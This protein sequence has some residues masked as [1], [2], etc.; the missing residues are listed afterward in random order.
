MPPVRRSKRLRQSPIGVPSPGRRDHNPKQSGGSPN[1]PQTHSKS[2]KAADNPSYLHCTP[3]EITH[4]TNI[5]LRLFNLPR[6]LFDEIISHLTPISTAS[7]SL[8]CKTALGVLGTSSWAHTGPSTR[9]YYQR[10]GLSLQALIQKDNP[11]L[12]LC[13]ICNVLHPSMKPPAA[14]RMTK[15]TRRC[16]GSGAFM[17]YWPLCGEGGYHLAYEHIEEVFAKK[18]KGP[19]K[20]KKGNSS[21]LLAR[22]LPV[23]L[24]KGDFTTKLST[25]GVKGKGSGSKVTYRLASSAYW[26]NDNLVLKQEH[27]VSSA[28][29]KSPLQAGTITSLP[30]R[31]CAHL[32]T[33]TAP[34]PESQRT[35]H[36]EPNGS[37]L[38]RAIV[39]AFPV[40]RTGGLSPENP[41]TFR[42]PC[43]SEKRQID[44]GSGKKD[45]IW[46]CRACPTKFRVTHNP[47]IGELVVTAWHCFGKGPPQAKKYWKWF[48]RR[49]NAV[50]G[51]KNRNSEYYVFDKSVPNFLVELDERAGTFL[52]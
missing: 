28:T 14:H 15:W 16:L 24:L 20:R 9:P 23:D 3:T 42:P 4:D 46:A 10:D 1:T 2:K 18:P 45:F 11:D 22:T 21:A 41:D 13:Y 48:V 31:V 25:G 29:P 6:E 32:T 47:S 34:T 17:D 50:L 26:I 40:T 35:S 43:P 8:T 5:Y 27:R 44:L 38:T 33:S 19:S 36:H 49:E 7:L 52:I 51:P 39:S 37:L 12:T 30:F